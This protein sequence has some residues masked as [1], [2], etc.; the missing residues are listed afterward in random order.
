LFIQAKTSPALLSNWTRPVVINFQTT[1]PKLVANPDDRFFYVPDSRRAENGT[2]PVI[3][4]V[5]L[6]E[7]PLSFEDNM[8][9]LIRKLFTFQKT[10]E[11]SRKGRYFGCR[12]VH[13][14]I[15]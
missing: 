1:L 15:K 6:G 2:E 11:I 9:T 12:A 8:L 4:C 14:T 10:K 5:F 7:G 13:L 3:T